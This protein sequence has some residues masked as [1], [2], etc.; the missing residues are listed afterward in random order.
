[1]TGVQQTSV[2]IFSFLPI[3]L[4]FLKGSQNIRN[5]PLASLICQFTI[6]RKKP[7]FKTA[8][9][10]SSNN[11]VTKRTN[12]EQSSRIHN[13]HIDNRR[14]LCA[15]FLMS[16]AVYVQSKIPVFLWKAKDFQKI[17][18]Y[19]IIINIIYSMVYKMIYNIPF[20]S[21]DKNKTVTLLNLKIIFKT[22]MERA[23]FCLWTN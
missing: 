11:I 3:I 20:V 7:N 18:K 10:E 22:I 4:I 19:N 23:E 13:C 8:I 9:F 1:M 6:G 15:Y 16:I 21:G 2:F 17:N 12:N 14:F 5:R